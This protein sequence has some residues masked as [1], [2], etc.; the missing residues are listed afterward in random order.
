MINYGA[1]VVHQ[2]IDF[3]VIDYFFNDVVLY[4]LKYKPFLD[5]LD[6]LKEKAKNKEQYGVK[7]VKDEVLKGFGEW[8][9]SSRG[10]GRFKFYMENNDYRVF[11]STARINSD[12]PQ[13]R[14]EIPAKTIFRIG[15]KNSI[16]LFERFL[17]NLY[18]KKYIRKLNR[19]DLATDV[20][21][22][23]YD[24]D[25]IYRFQ[26]RMGQA[27]FYDVENKNFPSQKEIY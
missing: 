20:W 13:V 25:D 2:G 7:F 6:I 14:V 26:T 4:E 3:F 10:N 21:G 5:K 19:I 1:K 24:L 27:N 23:M 8:F 9:V 17:H 12:I 16:L 15:I 22:V 11:V 18:S